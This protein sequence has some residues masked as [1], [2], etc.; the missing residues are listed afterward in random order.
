MIRDEEENLAAFGVIEK[1][2]SNDRSMYD[3]KGGVGLGDFMVKLVLV[4]FG[5]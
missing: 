3:I 2:S 4:R 1:I 5:M